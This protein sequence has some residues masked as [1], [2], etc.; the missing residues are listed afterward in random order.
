LAISA[1]IEASGACEA[2]RRFAVVA[3]EIR[4]LADHVVAST[5]GIR[6]QTDD[7]RGAVSTTVVAI[8][9]GANSSRRNAIRRS[10]KKNILENDNFVFFCYFVLK[11]VTK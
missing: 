2:G 9:S 4:N 3:E 1:T 10:Y 5:K 6:K 7:A 11:A 8:E